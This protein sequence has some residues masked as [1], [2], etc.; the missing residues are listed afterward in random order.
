MNVDLITPLSRV[1]QVKID[2][3]SVEELELLV[4]LEQVL[5]LDPRSAWR[6]LR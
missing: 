2:R 1:P 5:L 4:V 3:Q 6:A